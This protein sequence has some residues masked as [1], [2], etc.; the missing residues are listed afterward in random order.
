MTAFRPSPLLYPFQSRWFDG[1][2]GCLHYVDEGNGSPAILFLHGNPTWSFL[3][4]GVIS[5]LRDRFRCVAPDYLG[6]GL[7]ERPAGYGYTPAEHAAVV[8]ELVAHLGLR[9]LVVMGQDWGGP[10]G[11]AVAV[12]APERV[13]GLVYGNTAFW[14]AGGAAAW[15][16]SRVMSSPPLRWAIRE[17][18]LFVELMRFAAARRLTAEELDHYR[19]VQPTPEARAGIAEFPRQILAARGWLRELE[20]AVPS[21]LGAKPVLLVWGMRDPV[22]RPSAFIPRFRATFPDC[23]L[24]EL[25]RARH[26]I[27]EDAP[28]EIA[29]AI[30]ERFG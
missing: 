18:N 29:H 19:C 2:A 25:P 26:F 10:I 1:S 12:S 27:Q 22:F 20:L 3:Y 24:V 21:T 23:A 8:A 15:A 9:E 17:R 4:R 30:A 5:R 7:S 13:A 11:S 14:P 28:E 6:F 16:F